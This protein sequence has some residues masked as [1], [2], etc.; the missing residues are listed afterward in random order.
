MTDGLLPP[1]T[2]D[3]LRSS[4]R[5]P[6]WFGLGFIQL[7]LDD[8]NR[9]H[10]WHPDL[11]ADTPEEELHDHRYEF[12]SR[13]LRGT[14]VHETWEFVAAPDGDHEM[15]EVSCEPGVEAAPVPLGRGIVRPAGIYRMVEGSSYT[16]PPT[17]FH[18][19][20]A[21]RAVT[22]LNRGPKV[23]D[24]AR[25]LKPLGAETI[26]PFAREIPQALLWECIADL[27]GDERNPGYHLRRIEKGMLGE[28]SKIREE[29]E[30]FI[31]ATEQ[32]VSVMALVELSDLHGAI[33]AYLRK[34]HPSISV[35]DL[36]AMSSV[37]KR[38]F[39]NGRR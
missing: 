19:I 35:A 20:E 22:L 3:G 21:S 27:L 4:G 10:F 24:V 28:A 11:M 9:I 39:E 1:I 32:G 12:T 26:C 29:V 31:E 38:A 17:G 37:T 6:A 30:E 23:R 7:K 2:V 33:E 13:I 5:S 34:H 8:E 16:F 18:R 14:L 15:V 25:V 36:A